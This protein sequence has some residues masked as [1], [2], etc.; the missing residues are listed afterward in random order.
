MFY[1]TI[2]ISYFVIQTLAGASYAGESDPPSPQSDSSTL[3]DNG[4][5]NQAETVSI[6]LKKKEPG[7]KLFKKAIQEGDIVQLQRSLL[8]NPSFI[9]APLGYNPFHIAALWCQIESFKEL[10]RLLPKEKMYAHN[11]NGTALHTAIKGCT[12]PSV[13]QYIASIF[14]DELLRAKNKET[15]SPLQLAAHLG[16]GIQPLLE[17]FKLRNLE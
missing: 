4:S 11:E 12:E 1:R 13:I 5:E 14:P 9:E 2:L 17:T 10:A 15:L 7:V 8:E 3:V 16:N 6:E